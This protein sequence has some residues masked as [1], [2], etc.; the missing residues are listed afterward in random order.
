MNLE[1]GAKSKG[2]VAS[3]GKVAPSTTPLLIASAVAAGGTGTGDA[4]NF[5]TIC[6]HIFPAYLILFPSK[7][8]KSPGL[9]LLVCIFKGGVTAIIRI[10][11]PLCSSRRNLLANSVNL[12]EEKALEFS[13]FGFVKGSPANSLNGNLPGVIECKTTAISATPFNTRSNCLGGGPS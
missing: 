3:Y 9:K 7:F 13:P 11:V 12:F 10:L 2:R 4:P 6:F 8:S 1:T 5:S